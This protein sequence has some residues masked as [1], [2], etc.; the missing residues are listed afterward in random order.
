MCKVII[1]HQFE[2][3]LILIG[4]L[5]AEGLIEMLLEVEREGVV[6]VEAIILRDLQGT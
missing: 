2:L 5:V 3:Y 1:I 4:H 6:L